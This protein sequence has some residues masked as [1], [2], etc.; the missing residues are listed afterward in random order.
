MIWGKNV[1]NKYYWQN[2]ISAN[3]VVTRY[4]GAPATYGVTISHKFR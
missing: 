1:T 4:A 3:D 2:V